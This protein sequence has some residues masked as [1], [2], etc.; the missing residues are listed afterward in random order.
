[1]AGPAVPAI[2]APEARRNASSSPVVFDPVRGTVWTA[3]GDN[4]T[5]SQVDVDRRV[6]VGGGTRKAIPVGQ[7]GCG[8]ASSPCDIRSVALSPDGAALAAVDRA[9][10]T[11]TLLDPDDP[12]TGRTVAVGTSPRACV[13]D[14][15]NPRWL[16]VAVE[17]DGTVAIVDRVAA[18][19]VD[20]IPVGRLPSGLAVSATRREL[21]VAHRIDAD[22]TIIDLRVRAVAADVPL[23]DEPFTDRKKPNGKP[24]GFEAPALINDR[25]DAQRRPAD[26]TRAWLP[27]ELLAPTH[28]F[29][30]DETLFPAISVVDVP[31]RVEAQTDLNRAPTIAGRKNLFDAINI[32]GS[33]GQPDVFSQICAVAMHPIGF[34]AWGLACASEDLLVF[35]VNEGIAVD[36]IRGLPGDHP[37]GLAVDDTGQRIFVLE[38]Q[39]HQLLTIDTANGSLVAHATL[40]GDPI[41]LIDADPVP[42]DLRKG[43]TYFFRSNSS[44]PPLPTA[45]NNWMSC[46]GCHLDG[47]TSTTARFF[48]SLVPSDPAKDAQIGHLG[49]ADHFAP[50]GAGGVHDVLVALVDQGGLDPADP[51]GHN[52]TGAIDPDH[53]T[54]DAVTMAQQLQRVIGGD[55]PDQ[56]SWLRSA[57][58]PGGASPN[59]YAAWDGA[60]CGTESCHPTE[61][62]AWKSSLHAHAQGDAM[63]RFC[64]DSEKPLE[65]FCNGCHDPIG[66]RLG[67][68][69]TAA[70]PHG[71][72]CLG[73]HDVEQPIRAGGNADLAAAPHADWAP[74][75]DHA[76]RAH[77][78]L[79]KLRQPEFCG[80]C[81]QQFVP[82]TGLTSIGTLAEYHASG[83]VG[84]DR[85]V[86]C[87]M[88]KTGGVADH[89]FPGGNMYMGQVI[90]DPTLLQAQQANLT[91]AL[92][93]SAKRV[94]G[95]VEVIVRNRGAAHSFPTGVT[96]IREPWVE[97]EQV[98]PGDATRVLATYGGPGSGGLLPPG[99]A[100]LGTDIA[101][102]DG[103]V[104]YDHT[105]LQATAMPFDVRVPSGGAQAFFVAVPADVPAAASLRAVLKYRNV[106]TR[107]YRDAI[108]AG[109]DAGAGGEGHAPDIVVNT[110]TVEGP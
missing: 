70:T 39:S 78:A 6:L 102:A 54:G 81:H 19:V 106:A 33:D 55:L 10:G 83:Y 104:L 63:F 97:V 24:F 53:P 65:G 37:V 21:Y 27:H 34:V 18:A 17:G 88:T 45:G 100:R 103:G 51:T 64:L 74:G 14:A 98:D 89:R 58:L 85:C 26:G 62:A 87:H 44:K 15:A 93:L 4:G 105:L 60:Y 95:G 99:A 35:D 38:D 61:Y 73:C 67:A 108:A 96:D 13:W 20:T 86:D 76:A 46:G 42:A 66:V 72:T 1:M 50:S 28:P 9:G 47:F 109:T 32:L 79:E 31:Q 52:R 84:I 40:Y 59:A 30:F 11:V 56:P 71:V 107:Y 57:P 110:A 22:L 68:D 8:T 3:N 43:L 23:A 77:Q 80:G 2:I 48:E 7:P 90:G 41:S 94:A 69:A 5:L 36:A 75:Q 25:T 101:G 82:G 92:E 49:L 12:A 29:V 91:M 16:Y